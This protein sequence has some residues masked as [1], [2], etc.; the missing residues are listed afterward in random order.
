MSKLNRLTQYSRL[1]SASVKDKT[2]ELQRSGRTDTFQ[3][4]VGKKKHSLLLND[5]V[6]KL[7]KP[8]VYDHSQEI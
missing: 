6:F 2:V 8:V 5:P 3:I 1:F 4:N 7:Q